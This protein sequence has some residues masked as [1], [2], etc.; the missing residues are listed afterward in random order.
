MISLLDLHGQSEHLCRDK[1]LRGKTVTISRLSYETVITDVFFSPD[2]VNN[3]YKETGP[4][5]AG[6]G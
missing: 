2:S 6:F 1:L 5:G 3:V 4:K